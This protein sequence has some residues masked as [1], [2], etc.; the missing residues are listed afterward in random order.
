MDS[1][2]LAS[3]RDLVERKRNGEQ[4]GADRT[5]VDAWRAAIDQLFA[6]LDRAR[7]ESVLPKEPAN[8]EEIRSWLIEA[9]RTK[10]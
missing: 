1:Y 9:R 8:R 7:D 4:T 5:L 6:T 2:G 3:A 10:F